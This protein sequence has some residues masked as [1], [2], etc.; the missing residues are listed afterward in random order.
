MADTPNF[1]V[2]AQV[3]SVDMERSAPDLILL[4]LDG[5]Q[6]CLARREGDQIVKLN[7]PY[8]LDRLNALAGNVLA[9]DQRAL[10]WP[11]TNRAL[12]LCVAAFFTLYQQA[13]PPEAMAADATSG[14]Q[15]PSA[16]EPAPHAPGCTHP[17]HAVP[18][19]QESLFGTQQFT[20]TPCGG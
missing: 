1:R 10:T 14:A 15:A 5:R 13:L 3:G 19:S 4:S 8:E 17:A 20:C 9:G 18:P 7:G 2:I 16:P 11:Q 6:L 12:A